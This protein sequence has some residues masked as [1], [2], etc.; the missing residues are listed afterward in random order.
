MLETE[1]LSWREGEGMSAAVLGRED[2][3]QQRG[4]E[5]GEEASRTPSPPEQ[6]ALT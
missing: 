1:R 4:E 2:K 3:E 5:K 6:D